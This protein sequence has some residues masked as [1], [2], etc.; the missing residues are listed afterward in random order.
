MN[1]QSNLA[2]FHYCF[3]QHCQLKNLLIHVDFDHNFFQRQIHHLIDNLNNNYTRLDNYLDSII[4]LVNFN[5]LSLFAYQLIHFH[6]FQRTFLSIYVL[7]YV[8]EIALFFRN[9]NSF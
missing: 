9:L 1:F 3:T 2:T 7:S 4:V 6:E 8:G 5:Y